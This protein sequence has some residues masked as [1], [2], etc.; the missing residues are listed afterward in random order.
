MYVED[1]LS[2]LRGD[3]EPYSKKF[4]DFDEIWLYIMVAVING[5]Q[6][7]VETVSGITRSEFSKEEIQ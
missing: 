6:R 1:I 5:Y 2:Q 3:L 4:D 7:G